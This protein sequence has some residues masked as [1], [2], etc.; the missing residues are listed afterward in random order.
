MWAQVE[1]KCLAL[2]VQQSHSSSVHTYI[3]HRLPDRHDSS[4]PSGW[5]TCGLSV[6]FNIYTYC[7]ACCRLT[8][9]WSDWLFLFSCVCFFL[10]FICLP[11]KTTQYNLFILSLLPLHFWEKHFTFL[12]HR[13]YLT[14]LFVRYLHTYS[15]LITKPNDQTPHT[16]AGTL[17]MLCHKFCLYKGHGVQF[18][19]I[20]Y[21]ICG[22]ELDTMSGTAFSVKQS[23]TTVIKPNCYDH[24][25]QYNVELWAFWWFQQKTVM[26]TVLEY[27]SKFLSLT[28][29]LFWRQNIVLFTALHSLIT[30]FTKYTEQKYKH[31]TFVFAPIFH[32]LNSNI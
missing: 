17:E 27:I 13:I 4:H 7:L 19:G 18:W 1:I 2:S 5:S 22:V 10:K 14:A 25:N 3:K 31:N 15:V 32:E 26:E 6:W 12:L 16:S 11:N 29:F 20:Y 30:S 9:C 24:N 28:I 23:S 8:V 21:W